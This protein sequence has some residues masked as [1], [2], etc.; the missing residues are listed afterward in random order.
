V[1]QN[2]TLDWDGV[3]GGLVGIN[4]QQITD[5]L[6][7]TL[8]AGERPPSLDKNWGWWSSTTNDNALWAIGQIPTF[9]LAYD[10]AGDW[11]GEGS[12]LSGSPCPTRS[13]FSR[14]EL[15][16]YCDVNHF[17]SFHDGGGYWLLCDASVHFKTYDAGIT[18]I[19][20][21]ATIAGGELVP[22]E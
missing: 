13:Y 3:F 2:S 10:S 4:K 22:V 7:N 15:T 20:S 17:W 12:S 6:S 8:M 1:G 16:N 19:P 18:I 11:T 21:M 5:G 9:G 14:G